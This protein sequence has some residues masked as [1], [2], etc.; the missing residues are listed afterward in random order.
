MLEAAKDMIQ[1]KDTQIK[2][3]DAAVVALGAVALTFFLLKK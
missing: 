1:F 3:K 2:A